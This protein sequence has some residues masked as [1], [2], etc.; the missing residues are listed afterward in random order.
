MRPPRILALV[1][2]LPAAVPVLAQ[3]PAEK[4]NAAVAAAE[5]LSKAGD[6]PV[7]KLREAVTLAETFGTKDVRLL[8]SLNRLAKH[9][10]YDEE[11]CRDGEGK[12][13]LQRA[14]SLRSGIAPQD[15][16]Y[17][18]ALVELGEIT[19]SYGEYRDAVLVYGE[20]R[21]LQ[22]KSFGPTDVRMAKTYSRMSR[23]YSWQ[24][25]RAQ[26]RRTLDYALELQERAG[27]RNSEAYADLLAASA[28]L[29]ADQDEKQK[30]DAEVRRAAE[31]YRQVWT[32]RDGRRAVALTD[33]LEISDSAKLQEELYREIVTIRKATNS[34]RSG[35]YNAA[36]CGLGWFYKKQRRFPEAVRSYEE[37][38]RIRES[39]Q[40]RDEYLIHALEGL[41][42]VRGEQLLHKDAAA[43]YERSFAIRQLLHQPPERLMHA[44]TLVVAAYADAGDLVT[45]ESKFEAMLNEGRLRAPYALVQAAE[46]LGETYAK[47]G[48]P[49][50]AVEKFEIA[51]GTFE[52]TAGADNPAM[53]S[54]LIRLSRAYQE[55]GR[56]DDAN[57]VNQRI[58]QIGLSDLGKVAREPG[59]TGAIL[60]KA[61]LIISG[62]VWSLV[63]F[64]AFGYFFLAR[65]VD[66]KLAKLFEP[67]PSPSSDLQPAVFGHAIDPKS[68]TVMDPALIALL[69]A[70]PPPSPPRVQAVEYHGDGGD[71]FALRVVNLLFSLLTLGVYSFWGKAKVRRYLCG[72]AEFEG[73]R[74]EFHGNGRELFL[75][76]LK[77]APLLGF[78]I[79]FPSILPFFWHKIESIVVAQMVAAG[80]F[81]LL[82]PIARAGA[83][84]YRMN[85]MS[86][87]GIRFS[88]VG[89]TL[90]YFAI[91]VG[92]YILSALTL[93]IYVPVLFM[94][95]RRLLFHHTSFGTETFR[96]EGRIRHLLPVWICA[97]PVLVVTYGL[98]WPWW[99]AFRY[100]Y[101][102]ANTTLAGV[103]FRCTITGWSLARLWIGNAVLIVA[104][105]GLGWSWASI[106]T[107]RF[108]SR[109]IELVG[110]LDAATVQQRQLASS[111]VGESFADFLGFDFGF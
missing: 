25:D 9:C 93:G 86:W 2:C 97:L 80:A 72:Q 85:R 109:G 103:R 14:L 69:V 44:W 27:R 62:V 42:S 59:G 41:A 11:D 36:L 45:A 96:F 49:V 87:R 31:V 28:R 89:R 60:R 56:Y 21:D 10:S 67:Q 82:W 37:A 17:T 57:R 8:E 70:P 1:L 32:A 13:I 24:K 111:A 53:S 52:A 63:I 26:A 58:L 95:Q 104:T 76:W 71:L 74:F 30:A 16:R 39:A 61:A 88:F 48:D 102:W 33:L 54:K 6:V 73:D 77:G 19:A 101:V 66:R 23:V 34:E 107:L 51:S 46:K 79:L 65:R 100:R 81:L 18:E 64:G 20:A 105:L 22:E 108:W 3:T 5:S 90:R 12:G 92:G 29:L 47:F 38:I 40:L 50:R 98:F 68:D 15:T 84:R 94:Q 4:W 110:D 106:R 91:S 43:L 99:S 75:G 55:A 78:I 35:E 7:P 83:Y